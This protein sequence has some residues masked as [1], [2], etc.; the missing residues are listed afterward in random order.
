M[1]AAAAATSA[2]AAEKKPD[3]EGIIAILQDQPTLDRVQGSIRDQ[4]L[5]DDL[6]LEPTLESALRKVREGALPR[7]LIMDLSEST[8]PISELSAA[9]SPRA[10][11][12]ARSIRRDP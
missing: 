4:Q 10:R 6:T 5:D 12:S 11:K 8:S 3:R 1:R 2:P 9:R 7:I